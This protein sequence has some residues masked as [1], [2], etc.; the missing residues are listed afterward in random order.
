MN[1]IAASS[2]GARI[3]VSAINRKKP[4]AGMEPP[5]EP[6]RKREREGNGDDRHDNRDEKRVSQRLD[7][8][9]RL[10]VVD[11]LTE[12]HERAVLVLDALLDQDRANGQHRLVPARRPIAPPLLA[13]AALVVFAAPLGA[14]LV[15][16]VQ[17]KDGAFVGFGQIVDY[18]QSPALIES[19]GNT[20]FVAIVVTVITIPLAFT[21]AY[22]LT[23]KSC[24]PAKG[25]FRLI[26][27]T[28][29]LAPSLLAAIS[30]IQWFGNQGALKG[31]LLGHTVYGPI[32]I[33]ISSIYAIFP[34]ALMI[35]LTS[36]LL[37]DRRLA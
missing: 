4:F 33:V 8:R 31:L 7:Q 27:L 18:V 13:C 34:H 35:V 11:D 36:L 19:L 20:L 21:F 6:V 26:A 1:D 32:G 5:S 16:S 10:D 23:R 14:I 37:T 25:F 24:M 29:I 9:R 3:G 22:G 12:S 28:P 2:D 30:F 15:K 17:D